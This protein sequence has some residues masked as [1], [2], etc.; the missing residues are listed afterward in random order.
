MK[1]FGSLKIKYWGISGGNVSSLQN[2]K[3]HTIIVFSDAGLVIRKVFVTVV[4]W[5]WII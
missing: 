1:G 2:V 5:M 4:I 3:R